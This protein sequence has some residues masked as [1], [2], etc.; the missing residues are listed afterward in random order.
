MNEF[1][2]HKP[3]TYIGSYREV[4]NNIRHIS[5][6]HV[7]KNYNYINQDFHINKVIIILLLL[8]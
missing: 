2:S 7:W 6:I 1:Y 8:L 4:N 5:F 3:N